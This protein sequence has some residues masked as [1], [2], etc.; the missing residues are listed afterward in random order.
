MSFIEIKEAREV[1]PVGVE[2]NFLRRH[3]RPQPLGARFVEVVRF[4]CAD[5]LYSCFQVEEENNTQCARDD[6][7]DNC[8]DQPV[9]IMPRRC[10]DA[11]E[12]WLKLRQYVT[13]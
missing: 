12:K 7:R 5:L 1:V 6:A 2:D 3:V 4:A 11:V 8:L 9:V 10:G 13:R